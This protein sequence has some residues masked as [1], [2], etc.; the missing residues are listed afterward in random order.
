LDQ[1][2]RKKLG[3]ARQARKIDRARLLATLC[4]NG[5]QECYTLEDI[6]GEIPGQLKIPG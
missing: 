2:L 1:R 5:A 4:I 3:A 6:I